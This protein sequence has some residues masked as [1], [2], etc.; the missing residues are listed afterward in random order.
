MKIIIRKRHFLILSLFLAVALSGCG[1]NGLK[2]ETQ[3][4]EDTSNSAAISEKTEI[5]DRTSEMPDG[6]G[7]ENEPDTQ[8]ISNQNASSQVVVYLCGAV[9][10]EGLFSLESG[11][12]V[13]DALELAGGYA[14]DAA[15][16]YV[17]LARILSDGEKIYFPTEK[18]LEKEL[19]NSAW[20]EAGTDGDGSAADMTSDKSS[21]GTA[22]TGDKRVNINTAGIS[23]LTTLPG[24]G[25]SRAKDILDYREKN[26]GFKKPEDLMKVP[27]IKEGTF[28]KL[29]DL[30]K[31]Q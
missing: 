27:G 16:G 3:L 4:S 31:V 1:G 30:I 9:M 18:E 5:Q 12:R 22:E 23:E 26:G 7:S 15:R 17:N 24:I 20:Q 10:E 13:G 11:S 14:E 29:K 21:N 8:Y 6:S 2:I 19:E 25:E 28:N